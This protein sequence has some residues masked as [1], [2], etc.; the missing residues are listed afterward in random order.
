M[1]DSEENENI[2]V[3]EI[4]KSKRSLR[5]Y[6]YIDQIYLAILNNYIFTPIDFN[7]FVLAA[8]NGG[9]S[10]FIVQVESNDSSEE[11][12]YEE[13]IILHKK[14]PARVYDSSDEFEDEEPK[15]KKP[16]WKQVKKQRYKRP[17]NKQY[18]IIKFMFMNFSPNDKQM[19]QI[20]Q[21]YKGICKRR[22][23]YKYAW[24]DILIKRN[25]KFNETQMSLI[26]NIKYPK[27]NKIFSQ[28]DDFSINLEMMKYYANIINDR[29]NH[30]IDTEISKIIAY[31]RIIPIEY[32]IEF[33]NNITGFPDNKTQNVFI[34][35]IISKSKLDESIYEALLH[36]KWHHYESIKHLFQLKLK[37]TSD[38]VSWLFTNNVINSH[39]DLIFQMIS[40]NV[41]ITEKMLNDIIK[42]Q[43]YCNY[44]T[45][46]DIDFT[47][48]NIDFGKFIE[49]SKH[50]IYDPNSDSSSSSDS[51]SSC[52]AEEYTKT[53]KR[54]K[55]NTTFKKTGQITINTVDLF[56]L[57][58]INPS[59]DTLKI[60][61]EKGKVKIF[62]NFIIDYP[63]LIP[64]KE[65]LDLSMTTK[66]DK[67]IINLLCYKLTP[68]KNT[69]DCLMKHSNYHTRERLQMRTE[70]FIKHGLE[71][72]IREIE[73][74]MSKCVCLDNI[75]RFGIEYD[76][77]LYF[78][79]FKYDY[80][81]ESYTKNFTID[82]N[83]VTMREMCSRPK[84]KLET[85]VTFIKNKNFK[86]D[87]YCIDNAF[88]SN[89]YYLHNRF[90]KLGY[91]P[92][93]FAY[94]KT[95]TLRDRHSDMTKIMNSINIT[96]DEMCTQ[97]DILSDA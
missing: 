13:R 6:S 62:N 66:N 96:Y 70:I 84:I 42:N 61:C 51:N 9:S 50:K 38:Y 53:S 83:I 94:I 1:S 77:K 56:K 65:C 8:I 78:L 67:M 31:K 82:P 12:E 81:P 14:K 92:S 17:L 29:K 73:L 24:L 63:N 10:S 91:N 95:S 19:K 58:N 16:V 35:A 76:E 3:S 48:I 60:I 45:D 80:Y 5:D 36:K 22:Y 49:L 86:I 59:F 64:N 33:F 37:P 11:E 18:E 43:D 79:C 2:T 32:L 93:I 15:E 30:L 55:Y 44:D 89:N 57:L 41:E 85:L 68:D 87:K 28:Q 46:C 74:L 47:K 20:I 54:Y 72:T 27:I 25:F 97:L 26:N 39:I 21:C 52:D 34:E 23:G 4:L 90:S 88:V 40:I 7:N 69:F 71:I 75:E